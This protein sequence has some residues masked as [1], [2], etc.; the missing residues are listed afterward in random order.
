MLNNDDEGDDE[1][2]ILPETNL[3]NYHVSGKLGGIMNKYRNEGG[4]NQNNYNLNNNKNALL[5]HKYGNLNSNNDDNNDKKITRNTYNIE[6][7]FRIK[8]K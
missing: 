2:I 6:E 8:K 4:N 1:M 7:E 5:E 3:C